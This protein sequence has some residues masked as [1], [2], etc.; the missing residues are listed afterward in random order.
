MEI[1]PQLK[2]FINPEKSGSN[3]LKQEFFPALRAS[4]KIKL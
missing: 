2:Y 1:E 3:P 4:L